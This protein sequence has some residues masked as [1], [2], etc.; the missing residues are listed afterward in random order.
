MLGF[1][2]AMLGA[3]QVQAADFL[4]VRTALA[5]VAPER[6]PAPARAGVGRRL[7]AFRVSWFACSSKCVYYLKNEEGVEVE[8]IC[9]VMRP[10]FVSVVG[11]AASFRGEDALSLP[12]R[13]AFVPAF[14]GGFLRTSDAFVFMHI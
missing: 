14:M 9:R 5:R 13:P 7:S 12:R 10:G 4:L 1:F 2:S 11:L 3:K 8:L 6:G